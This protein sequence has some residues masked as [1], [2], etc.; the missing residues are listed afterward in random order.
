VHQVRQGCYRFR[1]CLA[2]RFCLVLQEADVIHCLAFPL[3][4]PGG[5]EF[6]RPAIAAAPAFNPPERCNRLSPL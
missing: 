3:P 4:S 1:D 2:L 5:G 6:R